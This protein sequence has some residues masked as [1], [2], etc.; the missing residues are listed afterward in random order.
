MDDSSKTNPEILSNIEKELLLGQPN[1]KAATGLRNYCIISLMLKYG[2]KVSEIRDLKINNINYH[3]LTIEVGESG[4]ALG[5]LLWIS[6]KDLDYIN[7]WL[8]SGKHNSSY[9]F[10][11]LKGSR[12]KD[13]YIREMVKRL[14]KKA[15]IEKD[16]HPYLLRH[17]FAIDLLRE[18]GDLK[19]L[20]ASLGHR[21]ISTTMFYK[22]YIKKLNNL[23]GYLSES[24]R[25]YGTPA[26]YGKEGQQAYLTWQNGRED[27]REPPERLTGSF[28]N[29]SGS[30]DID[31]V[32]EPAIEISPANELQ[33]YIRIPP[34]KCS[35]CDYILRYQSNCPKC[36]EIFANILKH[37]GR[38]I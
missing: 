2:L 12:I 22:N 5:R 34:I 15:G 4:G 28:G 1:K 27:V 23:N 29:G 17:T 19:L 30:N 16:V 25:R 6:R 21:D 36:N 20:Q 31:H 9:I 26:T 18:T 38:G 7:R 32:A 33:E 3:D 11:S 37:W 13:R 10:I 8:Q 35:N 14:A 24:G